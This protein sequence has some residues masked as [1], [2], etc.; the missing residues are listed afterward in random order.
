MLGSKKKNSYNGFQEGGNISSSISKLTH[1]GF[2]ECH[3]V[4]H[5]RNF[6]L[7]QNMKPKLLK[8]QRM[9]VLLQLHQTSLTLKVLDLQTRSSVSCLMCVYDIMQICV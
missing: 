6:N 2:D 5:K 3:R 8:T 4:T 1:M 9:F 7:R